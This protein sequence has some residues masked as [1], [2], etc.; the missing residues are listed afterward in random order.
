MDYRI[1]YAAC[2]GT[3]H[4]H[5]NLPC[6]DIVSGKKWNGCAAI[7]LADGAGSS[8]FSQYGAEV[9][10]RTV[11]NMVKHEGE[12]WFD[13]GLCGVGDKVIS[14]C[15]EELEKTPYQLDDL[16]CTLL[17]YVVRSDGAF[18]CG[19][20]GDGYMFRVS[21]CGTGIISEP[22][23]GDT[24]NET[25]FV[26]SPQAKS[27]M[28]IIRGF[29]LPEEMILLCSDGAGEALYERGSGSIA[30]ALTKMSN[31][32]KNYSEDEVSQALEYNLD[33]VFRNE[34]QDDMSI[35]V[36]LASNMREKEEILETR[37]KEEK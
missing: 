12:N 36:I 4:F 3:Y 17:F 10:V 9:V 31:W 33:N 28:R 37:T 6:Q 16:A 21:P 5:K 19:H 8:Q 18:I 24:R 26:T 14:E 23:N 15:L 13:D 2:R 29:Q 35:A 22:E 7:A 1:A 11:L 20:I 32:M 27:H 30:P 34:S 25:V